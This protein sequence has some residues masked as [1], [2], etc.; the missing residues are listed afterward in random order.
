MLIFSYHVHV[1]VCCPGNEMKRL[2]VVMVQNMFFT[3]KQAKVRSNRLL[4]WSFDQK[5]QKLN[6]HVH[7]HDHVDENECFHDRGS[8]RISI[9]ICNE[10]LQFHIMK[11]MRKWKIGKFKIQFIVSFTMSVMTYVCVFMSMSLWNKKKKI[12]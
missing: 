7:V 6:L 9:E 3:I 1:R 10:K 8:V 12:D 2:L 11:V 5:S 4:D